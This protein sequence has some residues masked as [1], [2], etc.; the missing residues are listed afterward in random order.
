MGQKAE[1]L[2]TS[3][4]FAAWNDLE[5]AT[6]NLG[7]LI[8]N[9]TTSSAKAASSSLLTLQQRKLSDDQYLALAEGLYACRQLIENKSIK[10]GMFGD[11]AWNILLDLFI[12]YMRDKCVC[13]TDTALAGNVPV[14]TALR[15]LSNLERT[16]FIERR[17]DLT[18]RR[19]SFVYLSETGISYVKDILSEMS[20]LIAKSQL[21]R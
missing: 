16:S 11:P 13:V 5:I 18:D 9:E 17:R 6:R 3:A 20:A 10:A 19:R 7:L 1:P 2:E 8:S 4:L 12:A 21:P 14:P 15:W